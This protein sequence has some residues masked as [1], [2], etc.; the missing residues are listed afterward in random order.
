[1]SFATKLFDHSYIHPEYCN[2]PR[3]FSWPTLDV[4]KSN[5]IRSYGKQAL[6]SS[7]A[8]LAVYLLFAQFSAGSYAPAALAGTSALLYLGLLIESS[9]LFRILLN[10]V[11]VPSIFILAHAS[12]SGAGIF[13]SAAFL[14]QALVAAIQMGSQDKERKAQLHCWACFNICLALLL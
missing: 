12:L 13:L 14:L 2:W 8:A 3:R 6:A 7:G 9:S 10:L 4:L 11:A 1:M 5:H